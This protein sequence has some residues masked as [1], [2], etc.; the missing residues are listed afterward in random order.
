MI[1]IIAKMNYKT[2][3]IFKKMF[4]KINNLKSKILYQIIQLNINQNLIHLTKIII[5]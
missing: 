3:K 5:K 2:L 4:N 1:N